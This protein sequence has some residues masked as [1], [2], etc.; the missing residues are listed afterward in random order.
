LFLI[1][2]VVA[3]EERGADKP[4]SFST[5]TDGNG[6]LESATAFDLQGLFSFTEAA[7]DRDGSGSGHDGESEIDTGPG[8]KARRDL[9][10]R[11]SKDLAAWRQKPTGNPAPQAIQKLTDKARYAD[12]KASTP[13]RGSSMSAKRQRSMSGES[14]LISLSIYFHLIYHPSSQSLSQEI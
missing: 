1:N 12:L 6:S 7:A 2:V 11:Q 5:N 3:D 14:L 4:P 9:T 10:Q 8:P 13:S